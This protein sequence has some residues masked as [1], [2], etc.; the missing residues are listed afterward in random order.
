MDRPNLISQTL[1][2]SNLSHNS[3]KIISMIPSLINTITYSQMPANVKNYKKK[4]PKTQIFKK[5]DL[6]LCKMDK[7]L[8]SKLQ[9]TN[10]QQ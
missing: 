10:F 1:V 7:Y 5:K 8:K 2:D 4:L 9:L 6:M 3:I